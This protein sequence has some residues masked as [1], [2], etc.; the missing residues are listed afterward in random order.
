MTETRY[1]L[2]D[3]VLRAA[4]WVCENSD[5]YANEPMTKNKAGSKMAGILMVILFHFKI[6]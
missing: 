2:I 3:R 5:L 4:G 1:E 6:S